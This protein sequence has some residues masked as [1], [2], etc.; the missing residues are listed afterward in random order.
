MSDAYAQ[1][2][3]G[4]IFSCDVATT[5]MMVRKSSLLVGR[6]WPAIVDIARPKKAEVHAEARRARKCVANFPRALQLSCYTGPV[7]TV[8][9][10]ESLGLDETHGRIP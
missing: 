5:D 1:V 8:S 10:W 4:I 7:T 6:R 2:E 3:S 9:P